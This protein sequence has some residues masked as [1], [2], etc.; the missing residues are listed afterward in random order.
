M[1]SNANCSRSGAPGS[2]GPPPPAKLDKRRRVFRLW[3]LP[4]LATLATPINKPSEHN[5]RSACRRGSAAP[6]TMVLEENVRVSCISLPALLGGKGAWRGASTR[7]MTTMFYAIARLWSKSGG[8]SPL[9][10]PANRPNS[11]LGACLGW[12]GP[13]LGSEQPWGGPENAATVRGSPFP[14]EV[15]SF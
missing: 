5:L 1:H 11:P 15:L 10:R 13:L 9:I 14:E 8:G 2:L 3:R 7:S 6:P 12:F 4:P